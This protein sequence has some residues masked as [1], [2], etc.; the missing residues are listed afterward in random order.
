MLAAAF[1]LVM[2]GATIPTQRAFAMTA[3][4]LVGILLDRLAIT[5]RLVAVVALVLLVFSPDMLL[6]VSFQMSFGA[7]VALVSFYEYARDRD[8]FIGRNR[9][10][11]RKIYTYTMGV[12]ATSIVAGFVTGVIAAHHF[13]MMPTYGLLAN[14]IAVPVMAIWVMP[15]SINTSP[16]ASSP[17]GN[18][19][20]VRSAQ[21]ITRI[22]ITGTALILAN[23]P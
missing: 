3:I 17:S 8:W 10:V 12:A 13:N 23:K 16:Q 1:Y 5:L 11:G 19:A 22:A 4:V 9:T 14:M 20:K 6:N 15:H 21:G 7:V 18:K 2:S